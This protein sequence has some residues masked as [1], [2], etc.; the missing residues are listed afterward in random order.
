MS[1]DD[2][3][4]KYLAAEHLAR[5]LTAAASH[6][7][8][9]TCLAIAKEASVTHL[10]GIPVIVFYEKERCQEVERLLASG[11]DHNPALISTMKQLWDAMQKNAINK[12]NQ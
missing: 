11:S 9:Q 2:N 10:E 5:K 1:E 12:S 3:N 4:I 6:A 7:N 8:L